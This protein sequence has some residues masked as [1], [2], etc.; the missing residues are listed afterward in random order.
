[1]KLQIIP[2][3]F[4]QNFVNP[5]NEL[6]KEGKISFF[7]NEES[8][9]YSVS[10]TKSQT[11]RLYNTYKPLL[12]SDPIERCS[13]N[14]LRLVKGLQCL[15]T[16]D[17]FVTLEFSETSQSCKFVAE[18]IKF[19]IRL[20]D[21]N[22][23]EVPKFNVAS[24]KQFQVDHTIDISVDKVSNI[25]KALEFA[26]DTHKFYLEQDRNNLYFYFGDKNA[27]QYDDI[28]VLVSDSIKTEIPQRAFDIEILKLVLKSKNDFSMK[29]NDKGVMYIEIENPNTNLKYI[30]TPLI[31]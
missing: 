12:I 16:D 18:D 23:V 8:E 9:I 30:T 15:K 3:E 13:I 27:Q 31:K 26:S 19:N 24:F 1:M 7:T 4:I 21:N 20:L 5:I 2:K 11:I 14:V 29:L 10:S 25:K 17:S 22:L 6:H 28:K